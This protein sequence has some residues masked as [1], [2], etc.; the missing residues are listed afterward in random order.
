MNRDMN[1]CPICEDTNIATDAKIVDTP[2]K[3][4]ELASVCGSCNASWI[5]HYKYAGFDLDQGIDPDDLPLD[6]NVE[7]PTSEDFEI[8]HTYEDDRDR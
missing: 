5:D 7:G 6:F 3:D 4:I 1:Q 2:V 8:L